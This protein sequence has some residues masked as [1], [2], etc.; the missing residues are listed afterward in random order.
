MTTFA[1]CSFDS[2]EAIYA[3]IC[4]LWGADYEFDYAIVV[5]FAE[6]IGVEMTE[7]EVSAICFDLAC[8]A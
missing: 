8:E 6:S 5:A 2:Y 4:E 7:E 3:R 1:T